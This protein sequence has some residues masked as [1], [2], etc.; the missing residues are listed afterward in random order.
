[1]FWKNKNK[2]SVDKKKIASQVMGL[3]GKVISWSKSSYRFDNPKNL[4]VFNAVVKD[5]NGDI[6]WTGDLDLTVEESNLAT[7]ARQLKEELSVYP[8]LAL[9]QPEPFVYK[10]DGQN[11]E[12]GVRHRDYKKINNVITYDR[13]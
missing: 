11:F 3:V 8:E 5:S 4:I 6:I 12:F 10:T 9:V 2:N 13:T 7:L 1:M